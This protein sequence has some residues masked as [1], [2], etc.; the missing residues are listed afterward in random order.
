MHSELERVVKEVLGETSPAEV[1]Y[2]MKNLFRLDSDNNGFIDF[3]ELVLENANLG[4]LSAE[5]ALWRNC[6]SEDASPGTDVNGR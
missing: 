2:V 1:D 6:P 4:Q 3:D 5:E